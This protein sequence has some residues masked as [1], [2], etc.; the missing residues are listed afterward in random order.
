[1]ESPI[2]NKSISWKLF[3]DGDTSKI[4]KNYIPKLKL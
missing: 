4:L 3:N 2:N 1:M